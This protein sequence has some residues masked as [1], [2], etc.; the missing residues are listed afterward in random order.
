MDKEKLIKF[1][2]A[3]RMEFQEKWRAEK[4]HS[5]VQEAYYRGYIH[6]LMHFENDLKYIW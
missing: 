2:E 1:L 4:E 6:A 5:G 3:K